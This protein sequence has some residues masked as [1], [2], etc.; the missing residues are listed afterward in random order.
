MC[1][2]SYAHDTVLQ[3]LRLSASVFSA[4]VCDYLLIVLGVSYLTLSVTKLPQSPRS[5][6]I[7]SFSSF[8]GRVHIRIS[9][10]ASSVRQQAPFF[11]MVV[12]EKP[13]VRT[14]YFYGKWQQLRERNG[15]DSA[16]TAVYSVVVHSRRNT[17]V[18]VAA[19][20]TSIS[21]SRY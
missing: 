17:L 1:L 4:P 18:V 6:R 14:C 9:L 19:V 16:Q 20:G 21:F 13:C 7:V 3:G 15:E 2:P 10:G 12:L 11:K 8:F 5:P